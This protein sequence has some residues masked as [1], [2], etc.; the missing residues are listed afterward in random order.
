MEKINWQDAVAELSRAQ[1]HSVAL[2]TQLKTLGD[3]ET[4][5]EGSF[6]YEQA[7]AEFNGIISGLLLVSAQHDEP[8]SLAGLENRLDRALAKADE[9]EHLVQKLI[10]KAHGEKDLGQLLGNAIEKLLEPLTK[11]IGALWTARRDDDR[12]LRETV[13][14]Q[15]ESLRWPAFAQIAA[16]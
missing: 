7:R 5:T 14:T 13:G 12:L 2:A 8:D 15:L 16:A 9:F 10:P 3:A 1:T 4:I 11:A 6:T